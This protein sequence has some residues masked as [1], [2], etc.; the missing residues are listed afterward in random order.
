VIVTALRFGEDNTDGIALSAR[1][2]EQGHTAVVCL[3]ESDDDDLV[4]AALRAGV[5]GCV[6]RNADGPALVQAVIAA[7]RGQA[8]LSGGALQRLHRGLRSDITVPLTPRE[9][10]VRALIETGLPDK[11]I[12]AELAISVKTVEKHVSSLLRKLD[13]RNR[14][15]LATLGQR[16]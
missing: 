11:L 7:G 16:R 13:V 14:T 12:A 10:E 8:V 3:A 1:L 5:H 6:D 4:V 9:R 15:E 2:I